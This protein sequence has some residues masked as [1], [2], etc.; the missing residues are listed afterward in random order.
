[1]GRSARPED[2]KGQYEKHCQTSTVKCPSDKIGIVLED[3][4]AI[5]SEVE[6]DEESADDPTEDN[7]GLALVV[8]DV[9]H[10]LD[11]LGHVDLRDV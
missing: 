10:I 3:T 7:A 11:E 5:V 9:A 6:L 1:M 8:R 4:R 2:S